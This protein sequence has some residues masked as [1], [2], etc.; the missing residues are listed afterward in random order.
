MKTLYFPDLPP[1]PFAK[2]TS[3]EIR[4]M[5]RAHARRT[6]AILR[7]FMTGPAIPVSLA[8]REHAL[9]PFHFGIVMHDGMCAWF[10]ATGFVGWQQLHG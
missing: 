5:T 6:E 7:E 10:D 9:D 8:T 4:K 3:E 1:S 2:T